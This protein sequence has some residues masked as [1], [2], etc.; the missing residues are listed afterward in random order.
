A[1]SASDAFPT[2]GGCALSSQAVS[3]TAAKRNV[4]TRNSARLIPLRRA[5]GR[6]D[7]LRRPTFGLRP[8][9]ASRLFRASPFYRPLRSLD[10][11]PRPLSGRPSL[12]QSPE[13]GGRFPPAP[14]DE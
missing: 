9:R 12:H 11:L 5:S 8:R 14:S 7:V 4:E 3:S 6:G 13:L 2:I 10:R 1:E